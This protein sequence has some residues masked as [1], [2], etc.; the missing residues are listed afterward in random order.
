MR[1]TISIDKAGRVVLPKPLRERFRLKEGDALSLEVKGD[2]IELRPAKTGK[3]VRVNG[4]LV[5]A[6]TTPL[7]SSVDFVADA[8]EERISDLIRRDQE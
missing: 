1:E 4:V 3:L 5:Y 7:P 6:G 8:R 2:A